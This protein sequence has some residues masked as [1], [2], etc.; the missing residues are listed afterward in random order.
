MRLPSRASTLPGPTSTKR[1]AAGGVQGEHGLAPAD[2]AR[3]RRGQLGADV[4]ERLRR[5][6]GED[7]ERAV[8]QLGLAERGAERL[9]GR[10]HRGRVERAGDV[11]RQA[12]AAALAGLLAGAL[13]RLAR[14]GQHDLAGRVVVGDGHARGGR[15]LR[16]V[17]LG[18][19]D[20]RQHRAAVA[21]VGHQRAAQHD[22][23]QGVV[24][25][26][27]AGGGERGQLAERV[28]GRGG[29]AVEREGV[30]AGEAGAEDRGLGEAGRLA[31]A[32]ER[33]LPDERDDALEQVGRARR[34]E[35]SHVRCLA[36]LA[37]EQRDRGGG[38]GDQAHT[39]NLSA[40]YASSQ[41]SDA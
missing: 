10:L 33:I 21:G 39:D 28:A 27:H 3:E 17:L 5:R 7:G 16:G 36:A 29:G 12:A 6:A 2:G 32:R 37:G 8:V 4:L 26:E 11:E 14:A 1:R 18:R 30:P 19:A 9:D 20:E 38:V 22:E 35:V 41:Q 15:D 24:A 13:E 25:V 40:A 34:D 31:G 23:P